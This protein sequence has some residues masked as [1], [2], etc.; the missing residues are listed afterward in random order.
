MTGLYKFILILDAIILAAEASLLI[1][2]ARRL[3][4]D[5]RY[6]KSLNLRPPEPGDFTE[7]YK[8]TTEWLKGKYNGVF[9]AESNSAPQEGNSKTCGEE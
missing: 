8:T 3:I 9:D 5:I 1:L 6:E 2:I 4:E 7:F